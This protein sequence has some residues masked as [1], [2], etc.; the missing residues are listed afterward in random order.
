M[1]D[2]TIR[3]LDEAVRLNPDD[4]TVY[5]NRGY[6]YYGIGELEK[7]IIDYD[8]AVRLCS[9]YEADFVES[10][11]AHGGQEAVEAAIELFESVINNPPETAADVYYIGVSALFW[12]D[13]ISA[14]KAFEIAL[15]LGY[16]DK[17]KVRQHLENLKK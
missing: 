13:R 15:E 3:E 12:N 11:F 6:A 14:Q 4:A 2:Q 10:D 8:N 17:E 7:A 16:K 9:N 5:L 1:D